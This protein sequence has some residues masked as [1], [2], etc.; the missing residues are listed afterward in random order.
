MWFALSKPTSLV[1]TVLSYFGV[2]TLLVTTSAY[3]ER[4]PQTDEETHGDGEGLSV[5]CVRVVLL[6]QRHFYC[7]NSSG[8][9][10]GHYVNVA[11][12]PCKSIYCT[13]VLSK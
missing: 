3:L 4:K 10:P 9:V 12:T 13:N 11:V 5:A 2:H 8:V 1:V 7:V 6:S